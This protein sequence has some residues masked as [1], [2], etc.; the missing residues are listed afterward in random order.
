MPGT[1]THLGKLL[2]RLRNEAG[3]TLYELARRTGI[4]RSTLM[5]I[6]D[7]STSQ[8]DTAT[9]NTLARVLGADVEQLYDALWQGNRTPL[10]SATTYF[11]SKYRLTDEQIAEVTA[12]LDQVATPKM[13]T[14]SI[15][16]SR[17]GRSS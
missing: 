16:R 17:E 14:K 3:L 5:R 15:K 10:P 4:N 6:E 11:R 2:T 8:P 7:G 9:L 13:K 12:A 1:P